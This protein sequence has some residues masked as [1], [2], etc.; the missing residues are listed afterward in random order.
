MDKELPIQKVLRSISRILWSGFIIWLIYLFKVSD[1]T[2][3]LS[4]YFI[5]TL[6]F[7][8]FLITISSITDLTI[9]LIFKYCKLDKIHNGI[10]Y[11]FEF[12]LNWFS[13][14]SRYFK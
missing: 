10:H 2:L 7:I 6:S 14:Y 1:R 11:I 8:L 5:L 13:G 3:F 9:Y 12:I 4:D